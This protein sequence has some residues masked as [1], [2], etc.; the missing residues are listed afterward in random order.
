MGEGR[1]L[2]QAAIAGKRLTVV[3]AVAHFEEVDMLVAGRQLRAHEQK[4]AAARGMNRGVGH[5]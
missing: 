2:G 1:R 3:R 5:R 4:P